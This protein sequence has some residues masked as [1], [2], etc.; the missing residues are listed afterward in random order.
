MSAAASSQ[1]ET[2]TRDLLAAWERARDQWHDSK[3]QHFGQTFIQPL[4]DLAGNAREA[5]GHLEALLRKIKH[6]CE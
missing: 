4:P 3:S 6:D 5:M 2:S 1:I